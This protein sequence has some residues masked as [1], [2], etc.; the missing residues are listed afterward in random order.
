MLVRGGNTMSVRATSVM[1]CLLLFLPCAATAASTDAEETLWE[2]ARE[3]DLTKVRELIGGGLDVNSRTRYDATA[4]AYASD[5][6]HLDVVKYLIEQGADVNTEDS[7]YEF[8]PIGWALFSE[9]VEIVKFLLARGAT[10]AD[11]VLQTGLQEKNEEL[12]AAALGAADITADAVAV[13]LTQAQEA[14]DMAG[15][16]ALLEAADIEVPER[17]QI[18]VDVAKLESYVGKYNNDETG[19]QLEIR[20]EEGK[21]VAQATGQPALNLRALAEDRFE[22]IEAPEVKIS[23]AGRGGITERVLVEQGSRSFDFLPVT[24]TAAAA[25]DATPDAE[26]APAPTPLEPAPRTAARNWPSFRG[27]NASGIADGQGA[28]TEWDIATGDNV[29]WK[30]AIPGI[31]NSSPVI[32]DDRVFVT[33]AI[34]GAND[35]TFRTGLYGDVES[36]DDESEH[37]FKVYA[38][39]RNTGKLLWERT[40]AKRVP[41]SKRHFKASQANST[42]VT[43][44]KRVVVLFGTIG[45]LVCYDVEGKQLWQVDVGVLDSGWF[46]DESY[47]W[48][49]ASSPLIYEGL[50]IVQ[51]DIQHDSF[52]AAWRLRDGKPAWRTER[53]EVPSWGTPTIYRG[54]KGDELITNGTTIRGYD[55][56]TGKELWSLGPNSEVTV[57]TPVVAGEL[58]YVTAGYPP[59]RPVY[60]I[61]SGARGDISLPE[62]TDSSEAIAWS[63]DRDGTYMPTPIVYQGQLYTC[64]NNG[65]LTAYDAVTGER[66]YRARVGDGGSFTASPIA[67]DGK[68]YFTNEDGDVF[69]VRAGPTYEELARNEMG[70][71]CMST[72]AIS[73][74][75]MVVRAMDHV[76]GLGRKRK[77]P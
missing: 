18:T 67:A 40:A 36:V 46:Y 66:I 59:V 69:V 5:K 58:F 12:V 41:G 45:M 29:L 13:A 77:L 60:A 22:A 9:H 3:G 72:P 23:F 76:Y 53:D 15:I 75:V 20:V 61:K 14:G 33:T 48:G 21:L 54:E 26:A 34:S 11:Q 35:D 37:T 2:A 49:H 17:E 32:W 44:G 7:F 27:D 50:V 47:Q 57:A 73:N 68:L 64:A 25:A 52:I 10:G 28:P 62:E 31:A 42:P 19:L 43:D 38:L 1:A 55:P 63:T 71:I 56:A 70:E 30:T 51:A 24:D 4:L 39:D 74:G 65:R 8:T 6:G 16:V